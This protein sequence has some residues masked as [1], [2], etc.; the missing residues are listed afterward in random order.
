MLARCR[1]LGVHLA[2]AESCTGGL[3]AGA[4]TE[5]AGSSDVVDRGFVTY[6]NG[7]KMD[8]LK[9]PADMLESTV[10]S[11]NRSP[12]LWPKVPLSARMRRPLS[13]SPELPALAAAA[14]T[15][16]SG[17][18]ISPVLRRD[19]TRCIDD[20]CSGM[21]DR[22]RVRELTVLAALDLVLQQL[23]QPSLA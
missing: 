23:H 18:C 6:S 17:W 3:I 15:S 4:L 7:A 22:A 1:E 13:R 11:A 19:S 5:I 14:R 2:T 16:R 12:A 8:L 10:R 20:A 9:V 21:S